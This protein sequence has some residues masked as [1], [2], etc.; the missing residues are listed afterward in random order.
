MEDEIE[1]DDF[2]FDASQSDDSADDEIHLT[3]PPLKRRR[4]EQQ[5]KSILVLLLVTLVTVLDGQCTE[6]MPA[7]NETKPIDINLR[8]LPARKF[9]RE[10]VFRNDPNYREI[11]DLFTVNGL[12]KEHI[13]HIDEATITQLTQSLGMRISIRLALEAYR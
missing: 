8:D 4:V 5:G 12:G 9:W 6:Q 10:E 1:E 2:Q 11:A 3:E 13:N 7:G